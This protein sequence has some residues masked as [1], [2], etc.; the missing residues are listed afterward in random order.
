MSGGPLYSAGGFDV[1]AMLAF[2]AFLI[3]AFEKAVASNVSLPG[4]RRLSRCLDVGVV[5]LGLGSLVI[6]ASLLTRL[7]T[8]GS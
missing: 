5:S 6:G 1:L 7:L 2:L 8:Q 4:S 3:L